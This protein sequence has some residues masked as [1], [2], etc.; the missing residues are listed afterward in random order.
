M[1]KLKG[2]YTTEQLAIIQKRVRHYTPEERALIKRP[3]GKPKSEK[4]PGPQVR[5]V[6]P[7]LI[8][9]YPPAGIPPV[10]LQ[11]A[12]AEVNKVLKKRGEPPVSRDSVRRAILV[13]MEAP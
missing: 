6:I 2:A 4:E 10:T 13:L 1:G 9:K 3:T 5:R 12:F 8:E 7:I 11:A